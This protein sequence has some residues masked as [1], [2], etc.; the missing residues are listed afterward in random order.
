[1]RRQIYTAID[2]HELEWHLR[3]VIEEALVSGLS[4]HE[5][6]SAAVARVGQEV[7]LRTQFE[8]VW[9]DLNPIHRYWRSLMA[10]FRGW[11]SRRAVAFYTVARTVSFITGLVGVLHAMAVGFF[12]SSPGVLVLPS[13]KTLNEQG[14]LISIIL[15]LG[16]AFNLLPFSQWENRWTDWLRLLYSTFVAELL[17]ILLLQ[18]PGSMTIADFLVVFATFAAI[19]TGPTLWMKQV[20]RLRDHRP[21]LDDLILAD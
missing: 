21:D 20:F 1:M 2:I 19:C 14:V 5:A 6:F 8:S 18:A 15:A 12:L 4:D 3:D 7:Q 16:S 10:E 17:L 11:P 13:G 9:N